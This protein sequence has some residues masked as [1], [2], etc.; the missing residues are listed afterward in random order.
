MRFSITITVL[1]LVLIG[2][3]RE[4][5]SIGAEQ[6]TEQ[7]NVVLILADDLGW[8]DLACYGN[9]FNETPHIDQL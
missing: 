2:W 9:T 3:M 4:P 1:L 8:A 6:R 5:S 7:P